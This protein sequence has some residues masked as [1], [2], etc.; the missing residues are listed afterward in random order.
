MASK[1]LFWKI[2][3]K[4]RLDPG[5]GRHTYTHT[6][7]SGGWGGEVRVVVMWLRDLTVYMAFK[8]T[9]RHD[10]RESRFTVGPHA[11][12]DQGGPGNLPIGNQSALLT[13]CGDFKADLTGKRHRKLPFFPLTGSC[14]GQP[15]LFPF[16][17]T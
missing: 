13:D 8:G 9:R 1:K 2:F 4:N 11:D 16:L 10:R 12:L 7:S 15:L 14:R 5:R 6:H 17:A 3:Q